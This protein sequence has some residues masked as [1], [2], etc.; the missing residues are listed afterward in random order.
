MALFSLVG[1]P[2]GPKLPGVTTWPF[3]PVYSQG[4]SM[5][6]MGGAGMARAGTGRDEEQG[7]LQPLKGA[8]G[9]DF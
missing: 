5:D 7:A 4:E 3:L 9:T 1:R 6:S 8:K 2:Q